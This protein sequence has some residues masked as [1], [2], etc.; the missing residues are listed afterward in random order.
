MNK[1]YKVLNLR[2]KEYQLVRNFL[3]HHH[4][5]LSVNMP[6]AVRYNLT[7][8][9]MSKYVEL[10]RVCLANINRTQGRLYFALIMIN[11]FLFHRLNCSHLDTFNFKPVFY[12]IIPINM[13]LLCSVAE[14]AKRQKKI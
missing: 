2:P 4:S 12:A 8:N 9:S 1:K 5:Q 11:Y 7:T 6:M 10:Q 13:V 14:H 3:L